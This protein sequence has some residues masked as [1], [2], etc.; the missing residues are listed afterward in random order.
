M[1]KSKL[2]GTEFSQEFKVSA[3]TCAYCFCR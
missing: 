2:T 3:G 1:E